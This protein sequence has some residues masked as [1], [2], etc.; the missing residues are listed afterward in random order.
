MVI[1]RHP[2][3]QVI[4]SPV[5]SHVAVRNPPEEMRRAPHLCGAP[6]KAHDLPPNHEKTAHKF[7]QRDVLQNTQ[8]VLFKSTTKGQTATEE[9]KTRRHGLREIQDPQLDTGTVKGHQWKH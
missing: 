9:R 1:G 8:P 4:T 3:N 6:P 5:I 2:F 7:T